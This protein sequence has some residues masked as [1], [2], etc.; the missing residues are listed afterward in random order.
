M[1]RFEEVTKVFAL[2]RTRARSFQEAF[3]GA[4]RRAPAAD[5]E[6]LVALDRVSFALEPGETLGL[7]GPN[8]TGKSTV[9]KLIARILEP[10][11]G[12]VVVGGRVAALLELGAGFHPELT[13]RENVYL[14]GS[15]M[16]LGRARMTERLARIA[17]FAELG[18]FLDM[19]VKHYS[20]GMYMRLGFATAIHVDADILLV[21]EVLAVGD[22]AFQNKCRERI[23]ALR[24]AGMTIVLV[25]HSAES[26]RELCARALWLEGGE[27]LAFGPTDDVLAAYQRSVVAHEEARWAAE[28]DAAPAAKDPPGA[29]RYGSGEIRITAVELLDGA[30]HPRHA[31]LTGEPLVVR[32]RYAADRDVPDAVFGIGIHAADGT[33]VTGPNTRDAGLAVDVRAGEGVVEWRAEALPLQEGPYEL[34]AAVYD[35]A[36]IHAYDHH[37]RRFALPVRR[38]GAGD[39]LGLVSIPARWAH[40]A[41]PAAE[42]PA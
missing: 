40:R 2:D 15:L 17:D 11:A 36:C 19:P 29:D 30:G 12:R 4:F 39:R 35:G 34:S 14:N 31:A 27:V 9:L 20:S 24:K 7:V 10:D 42:G 26:V 41:G 5:R 18:R 3:V 13:G 21:D 25:S 22:Q 28:H 32:L 37:H 16:G 6:R 23:A 33:H 38:G 1:L 8:G